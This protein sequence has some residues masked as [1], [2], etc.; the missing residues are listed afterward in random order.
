MQRSAVSRHITRLEQASG[1]RLFRR[2]GLISRW[3]N[4][5]GVSALTTKAHQTSQFRVSS[6][7]IAVPRWQGFP[8]LRC[9]A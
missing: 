1:T 3:L 9:P 5:S 8:R 7:Q 4:R 6:F 2:T